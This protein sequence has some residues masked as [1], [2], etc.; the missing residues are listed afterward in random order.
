MR[1]HEYEE[2]GPPVILDWLVD[3]A[4]QSDNNDEKWYVDVAM[5]TWADDLYDSAMEDSYFISKNLLGGDSPEWENANEHY[6]NYD[7]DDERWLCEG[8]LRFYV[9]QSRRPTVKSEIPLDGYGNCSAYRPYDFFT[10]DVV[11]TDMNG[12]DRTIDSQY[13][14]GSGKKM[15]WQDNDDD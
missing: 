9:Y 15:Y 10:S 2:E 14:F 11:R 8:I 7:H 5:W 6:P 1:W 3:E 4:T 13:S 12:D